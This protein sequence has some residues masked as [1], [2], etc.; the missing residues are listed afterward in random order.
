MS[1]HA[2]HAGSLRGGLGM[3]AIGL[4]F[5]NAHQQGP[6]LDKVIVTPA[7]VL[8]APG[9]T[10]SF[11]A[12]GQLTNGSARDIAVTWTAT[13]GT[14][15]AS[16][17]YTAG[18]A[19]GRYRVIA[20]HQGGVRAD[21]STVTIGTETPGP[22]PPTTEVIVRVSP[23]AATA[24]KWLLQDTDI[25]TAGT[26]SCPSD[27]VTSFDG[28]EVSI[29]MPQ[30]GCATEFSVFATGAAPVLDLTPVPLLMAGQAIVTAALPGPWQVKLNIVTDYPSGP[31]EAN[32]DRVRAAD[33]FVANNM[34]IDITVVSTKVIDPAVD[35]AVAEAMRGGCASAAALSTYDVTRL[36]VFY[37]SEA[38]WNSDWRDKEYYG[39]NCGQE[40]FPA[41]IFIR[42]NHVP[43]T[44]AHEIGHGLGLNHGLAVFFS[45]KNLMQQGIWNPEDDF[46]VDHF[47]L[48]QAFR[49]N[50][51]NTSWLNKGGPRSGQ[52]TK[53][54]LDQSLG[55]SGVDWPCPDVTL[56]W[57]P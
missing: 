35:V 24:R 54:C 43:E 51:H 8:L 29:G 37:T 27:L 9:A 7:T 45:D 34:G 11:S 18:S 10:E 12:T 1:S 56:E 39:Y 36:N 31:D 4:G 15:S 5:S 55:N 42:E 28:V 52:P 48:G 46:P 38:R 53:A 21:T 40:G 33:L 2:R 3:L 22:P 41:I 6:T 57:S 49:A 50:F 30:A 16:G 20:V 17:R 14:I 25:S 44:L 13:G 32:D 19:V 26:A 47:T 23:A